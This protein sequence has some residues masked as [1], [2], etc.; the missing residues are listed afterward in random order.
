MKQRSKK[1]ISILIVIC[2]TLALIPVSLVKAGAP[3]TITITKQPT[4]VVNATFGESKT[5]IW[6]VEV[7]VSSGSAITFDWTLET[8]SYSIGMPA[9]SVVSLGTKSTLTL[10]ADDYNPGTYKIACRI[11]NEDGI[12][13]YSD[14]GS[15]IIDKGIVELKE[16]DTYYVKSGKAGV[17]TLPLISPVSD[18]KYSISGSTSSGLIDGEPKIIDKEYGN[19]ELS[20]STTA[21]PAGAEAKIDILLPD[22]FLYYGGTRTLTVV[23]VDKIPVNITGITAADATYSGNGWKGYDGTPKAVGYEGGFDCHYQGQEYSGTLYDSAQ[24][25]VN[26]GEYKLTL[27]IPNTADYKGSTEIEFKINKKEVAVKMTDFGMNRG[28]KLFTLDNEWYYRF[29]GFIEPDNKNNCIKILPLLQYQY[30]DGKELTNTDVPGTYQVGYSR[31]ASLTKDAAANY[32]LKYEKGLLTI[33]EKYGGWDILQ[34]N[35]PGTSIG[36]GEITATVANSVSSFKLDFTVSKGATWKLFKDYDNKN[37]TFIDEIPG[38]TIDLVQGDNILYVRVIPENQGGWKRYKL[39]I[40]RQEKSTVTPTPQPSTPQTP[41]G[42]N[43][44]SGDSVAASDYSVVGSNTESWNKVL[45]G[46]QNET[47]GKLHVKMTGTTVIPGTVLEEL[48]GKNI[49]I[50][51]DLG[52]GI[53]WTIHGDEI[54]KGEDEALPMDLKDIDMRAKLGAGQIPKEVLE[55]LAEQTGAE[56]AEEILLLSLSHEGSFGFKARLSVYVGSIMAGRMANLFYYNKNTG[57]LEIMSMVAVD[58][59]GYAIFQFNHASDYAIV[60]DDGANLKNELDKMTLTPAKKTLYAGGNTGKSTVLKLNLPEILST[61]TEEDSLYPKITYTS[62]NP[63]IVTVSAEGKVNAKKAGKATITATVTAGGVSRILT[64]DITVKKAYLKLV[65]YKNSL[66]K[67]ESFTYTVTGYGVSKDKIIWG[68]TEKAIVVIDKKTG[69]AIANT[70][71]TDT[72]VA[73]YGAIKQTI[74]VT[75]K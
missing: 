40:T 47:S 53:S 21:Q 10:N 64:T 46:L 2:L 6:T 4:E 17:Y 55:E 45:Q 74:K 5:G 24:P 37:W 35:L 22:G 26:G 28:D 71:G 12:S 57:K 13:V 73:K 62:S 7:E 31:E 42:G 49:N 59:K 27:S 8:T 54:D 39:I 9:D 68:T 66:D 41:S 34:T 16:F 15:L 48:A 19:Y 33:G 52:D 14:A 11:K 20:F 25:P 51:F 18:M 69:K 65:E 50:T 60:I 67:G 70:T 36:D 75:V 1:V 72:V 38:N 32:S 30:L 44:S 23:A 3:G 58:S 61:L 63:K 29:E 56:A 43:T